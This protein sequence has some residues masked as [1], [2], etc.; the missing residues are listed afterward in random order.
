MYVIVDLNS[1]LHQCVCVYILRNSDSWHLY[2][3]PFQGTLLKHL[4]EHVIQ[5]NMTRDDIML[6]YTTVC[7]IKYSQN[8]LEN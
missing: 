7:Q 5:G 6:Y 1:V 4:E 2:I 8:S 3:W